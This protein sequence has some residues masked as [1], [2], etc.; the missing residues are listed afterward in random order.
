MM[1]SN[2]KDA[3]QAYVELKLRGYDEVPSA[4]REVDKFTT[5]Y[6]RNWICY[7]CQ[8]V[9]DS[10][11]GVCPECGGDLIVYKTTAYNTNGKKEQSHSDKLDMVHFVVDF[12]KMLNQLTLLEQ[13]LVLYYGY[14]DLYT[15]SKYMLEE[16]KLKNT[17]DN[18]DHIVGLVKKA[19]AKLEQI[20]IEKEYMIP[21]ESNDL[22]GSRRLH[23]NIPKKHLT[24]PEKL[25]R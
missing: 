12:E 4:F 23:K 11:T 6:S 15:V 16:Y 5:S 22:T 24:I 17:C 2:V 1:F 7:E 21:N 13:R 3:C 8:H 19:E 14:S 9:T 18:M 20:L 25:K 10:H